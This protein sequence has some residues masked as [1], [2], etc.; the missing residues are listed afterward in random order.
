MLSGLS[1]STNLLLEVSI[2]SLCALQAEQEVEE[3]SNHGAGLSQMTV[4]TPSMTVIEFLDPRVD[5][6]APV[7]EMKGPGG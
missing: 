1:T 2:E 3:R 7:D 6:R 5:V 4:P